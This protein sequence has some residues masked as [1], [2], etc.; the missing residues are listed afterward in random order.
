MKNTKDH[1]GVIK[2]MSKERNR[3]LTLRLY[4]YDCMNPTT[5]KQKKCE[6][7]QNHNQT[8]P[9]TLKYKWI[10][11]YDQRKKPHTHP[12]QNKTKHE[13]NQNHDQTGIEKYLGAKWSKRRGGIHPRST[14]VFRLD[15]ELHKLYGAGGPHLTDTETKKQRWNTCCL[16][17]TITK[18]GQQKPKKHEPFMALS[19]EMHK[20]YKWTVCISIYPGCPFIGACIGEVIVPDQFIRLNRT[21]TEISKNSS[22]Y[23]QKSCQWRE[24]SS[25]EGSGKRHIIIYKIVQLSL[26]FLLIN[27][28]N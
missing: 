28:R 25:K 3:T 22:L 1:K 18:P 20:G 7:Y 14:C 6:C 26:V 15:R 16:K 24:V 9:Q 23:C 17:P 5:T 10:H 21:S 13:H 12:P 2:T 19:T 27:H 11:N 8:S 4:N